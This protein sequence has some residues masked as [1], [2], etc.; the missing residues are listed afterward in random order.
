MLRKP[1]VAGQFYPGIAL[2]LENA[3]RGYLIDAPREKAVA[4]ISP[5][6][7]YIYS[8]HVAGALFSAIEIPD[9]VIL[10]GPNHTGL[11]QRASVMGSGEWEIPLGRMKINEGLARMLLDASPLFSNDTAAHSR[12]HSLEVQLPFIYTLNK[13]ASFVPVTVMHAGF[14][15]C[16]EMGQAIASVIASYGKETL[17][18]VSS[19]MNHYESDKTTRKKDELAI[20]KALALDAKGLLGVTSDKD[21]TM[22]G[23]IPATIAIIAAKELGASKA[24]LVKYATSGETSGDYGHVVGYAGIV[25]S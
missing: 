6:A 5:H 20:Q 16:S 21:I 17:I 11:G 9:S 8:G 1:A 15:E 12:E 24:R 22:C 10:I 14:K 19:D 3:V 18:L 25:I 7:G 23:V 4:A 2:Q 13:N